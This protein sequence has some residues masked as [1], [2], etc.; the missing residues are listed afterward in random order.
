MTAG[1]RFERFAGAAARR[2]ALTVGILLALALGGGLLSLGLKPSAGTDTFVSKSSASY[3]AT[4]DD[5]RHFGADPIVVLIHES[6]RTWWRP[7]I[8]P[9]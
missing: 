2:P 9:R 5:Q 6:C 1:E 4:A 7:R 8:W 3:K